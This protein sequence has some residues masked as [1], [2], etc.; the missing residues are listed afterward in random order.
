MVVED[1]FE[2]CSGVVF[3]GVCAGC[4]VGSGEFLVAEVTCVLSVSV[5]VVSGL[6]GEIPYGVFL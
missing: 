2:G 1:V 4:G 5:E 6:N 3:V